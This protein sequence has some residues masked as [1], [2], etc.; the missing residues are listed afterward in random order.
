MI[1]DDPYTVKIQ[2]DP[3]MNE[4]HKKVTSYLQESR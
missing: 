3:R 2:L 1:S 4:A